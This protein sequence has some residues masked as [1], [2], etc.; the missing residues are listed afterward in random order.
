MI[1]QQ[2]LLNTM[3]YYAHL[4]IIV[5]SYVALG[6]LENSV[7][8]GTKSARYLVAMTGLEHLLGERSNPNYYLRDKSFGKRRGGKATKGGRR[9]RG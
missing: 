4:D 1:E 2:G 8:Y 6:D 5:Q 3:I 9:G 7:K